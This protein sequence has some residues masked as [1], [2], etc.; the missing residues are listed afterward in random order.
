MLPILPL[1]FPVLWVLATACGE[2]RVLAQMSKASPSSLVRCS[3]TARGQ[4]QVGT[5]SG[6]LART[7]VL[8]CWGPGNLCVVSGT[9]CYQVGSRPGPGVDPIRGELGFPDALYQSGLEPCSSSCVDREGVVKS[10]FFLTGAHPV[11]AA[12]QVLRGHSQQLY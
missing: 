4:W 6:R 3:K 10:A 5:D 11:S 12:G 8:A 9:F 1:L 2:A 7:V